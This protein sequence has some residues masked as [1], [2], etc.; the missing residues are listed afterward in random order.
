MSLRQA[1]WGLG[2]LARAAT[3]QLAGSTGPLAAAAGACLHGARRGVSSHAENTNTFLREVRWGTTPLPLDP[4]CKDC[5]LPRCAVCQRGVTQ[6]LARGHCVRRPHVLCVVHMFM[7]SGSHTVHTT[8][9]GSVPVVVAVQLPW[10]LP[11]HVWI[12]DPWVLPGGAEGG[13]GR[14]VEGH[15]FAP[16]SPPTQGAASLRHP[17]DGPKIAFHPSPLTYRAP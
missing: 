16:S 9:R 1:A 3:Q 17:D 6:H 2:L 12:P 14:R 11:A 8:H 7:H 5:G 15:M 4:T 13:C 10:E